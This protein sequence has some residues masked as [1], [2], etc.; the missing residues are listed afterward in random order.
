MLALKGTLGIILNPPSHGLENKI[1]PLTHAHTT[2]FAAQA[3]G[4]C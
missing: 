3:S 4:K 1:K 2:S